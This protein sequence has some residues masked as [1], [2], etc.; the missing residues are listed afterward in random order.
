MFEA[1]E[2][3]FDCKWVYFTLWALKYIQGHHKINA[4]HAKWVEFL[5]TFH[6]NTKLKLGKLNQGSDALPRLSLL[7][8]QLDTYILGFERLKGLY[9]IDEDF[10]ELYAACLKHSKND[11]LILDGYLFKGTRLCVPRSETRELLVRE[12]HWGSLAA[13]YGEN[14]TLIMLK[15]HY[16]WHG[17]SKNIQDVINR[18]VTCQIVKSHLLPQGLYTPLPVPTMPWVDVIMNFVLGLPRT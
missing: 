17:M 4:R 6:F 8:F 9:V 12:V 11:F 14:K 18:C 7:L 1:L 2:S 3:L 10:R 5:Q 16:H 15:E 13:H